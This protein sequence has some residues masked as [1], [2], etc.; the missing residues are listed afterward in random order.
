[1]A[2]D[3]AL[4]RSAAASFETSRARTLPG[5][6]IASLLVALLVAA[7]VVWR[8]YVEL[9]GAR[10]DLRAQYGL[11]LRAAKDCLTSYFNQVRNT[12][13]TIS[14][15]RNVRVLSTE[16][17]EFIQAIYDAN[18]DQHQLA[19]VYI[20]E[21]DFDGGRRPIMAFEKGDEHRTEAELHSLERED[22][23][24][25]A[26]REQ[27][28]LFEQ[29]DALHAAISPPLELC[30]G[31][32]GVVYSVPIRG[33]RGL[34]GIV[35]GMVPAAI[36]GHQ[37][38][39]S[40][41]NSRLVLAQ[42]GGPVVSSNAL[43]D[44][45]PT[46]VRVVTADPPG[47]RE[48]RAADRPD[49][50]RFDALTAALPLAD[51]VTWQLA[52]LFDESAELRTNRAHSLLSWGAAAAIVG[53]GAAVFYLCRLTGAL[54]EARHAAERGQQREAELAHVMRLVTVSELTTGLAHE[55]NQ[56][57]AAI[58]GY[59]EACAQRAVAGQAGSESVLADLREIGVQSERAG[60]IIQYLRE[61][62]RKP[63]PR[64]QREDLN[65][66]AEAA[67]EL[68]RFELRR[69]NVRLR[70][71]LSPQALQVDVESI[72]IEQ[73]LVNLLRNAVEVL[74]SSAPDQREIALRTRRIDD[75]GRASCEVSDSGPP[76][77]AQRIPQMFAPFYS[78]KTYGLGM[79]LAISRAIVES[80][81]GRLSARPGET[82][83]MVFS[84]EL[85]LAKD[86]P[87]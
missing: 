53:L 63:R 7:G 6:G 14:L 17:R 83:G 27:I 35:A 80:H 54:V 26:Q 38:A 31:G 85:P 1:M 66:L 5:I 73:V 81:G 47:E 21:R 29:Q 45:P 33:A 50:G 37:L 84:L 74:G 69:G 25:A 82:R 59:A 87:A 72:A 70:M 43:D 56:P 75:T 68:L 46:A 67:S 32:R 4:N 9:R 28:R 49:L 52:I 40:S 22:E 16:S 58:A 19:E 55:L 3:T 78:T 20:I 18:Y 62:V 12:L 36:L 42:A 11:R 77:D 76:V 64:R 13:D 10:A 24:Y 57:L 15:D 60:R 65:R 41:L 51:G 30:V 44:V 86:G 71:E 48:N 39:T 2:P 79:G 34:V 8:G 61:F 23:E